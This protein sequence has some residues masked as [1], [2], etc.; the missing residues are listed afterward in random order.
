[1]D[2]P[3]VVFCDSY[4]AL[5]KLYES[6]L[7]KHTKII[8]KSPVILNSKNHYVQ[9]LEK[10]TN[11]LYRENFRK[12]S[13]ILTYEIFNSLKKDKHYS[14]YSVLIAYNFLI[15][16]N[17]IYF[18]SLLQDD[19]LNK[20]FWVIQPI[21]KENH[22]NKVLSSEIYSIL[23]MHPKCKIKKIHVNITK[24]RSPRGESN[25]NIFTRLRVVGFKGIFWYFINII[26]L[27]FKKNK[28]KIAII[29]SNELVRDISNYLLCKKNLKLFNYKNF[30]NGKNLKIKNTKNT[31][32][33]ED[34]QKVISKIFLK[35]LNNVP[36]NKIK[37]LLIS[38]WNAEIKE[39]INSYEDYKYSIRGFLN[40]N[41]IDII[42]FGYLGMIRGLALH[43]VC[44]KKKI[45]LVSCQ[46]GIT[47]EI[48][49]DPDLR[50]I[51]FETS[52]SDYFFCY[53]D[54]SKKVTKNSSYASK[55]NIYTIGLPSDYKNFNSKNIKRKKI[56][57]VSTI[58][59]SGGI[60]NLI[61]PEPDIKLV[62]WEI[63]LINKV[64]KKIANKVNYKP[65]PAIRYA[66]DDIIIKAVRESNNLKIV[67]SH[68]DF[69]YIISNYGLL[70]TSGATSTL[71]WCV[72]SAIPLVFINRQGSLSIKKSILNDFEK[73]F[74]VFDDSNTNWDKY[75]KI[76][77][78][79]NYLDI[80]QI[81]DS[82]SVYRSM[83]IKKY[84]GDINKNAGK[85]G[86]EIIN[87]LIK[88]NIYGEIVA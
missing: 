57:Y 8:T 77:L 10:Y 21:C 36:S 68:I 1:M 18:G 61:A 41:K 25:V 11:G 65:Y 39:A 70:I 75:L 23:E 54:M 76:F 73:A 17:K 2:N 86:A 69:R 7:S 29:S 80:L 13:K 15:F 55:N 3:N 27:L 35:S 63:K 28:Y 87:K 62:D 38:M 88:S 51:F 32:L 58:L 22:I 30:F 45:L 12:H 43:K 82:K 26:S 81:W 64:F 40:N 31:N 16:F 50:S 5:N 74:F 48:I 34:I 14:E 56:C 66:E 33:I 20:E 67:G 47:R 52:F 60:P 71:G 53:N 44:K 46:H 9:N 79:K 84:F 72:Q 78:D 19:F 42:F 85:N 83:V 59:L 49:Y 37:K 6:G 4:E 24:E